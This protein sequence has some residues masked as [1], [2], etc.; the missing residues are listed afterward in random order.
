MIDISSLKSIAVKDE[1]QRTPLLCVTKATIS[2][3]V[4]AI[5]A[6]NRPRW[7]KIVVDPAKNS[8]YLLACN[9]NDTDAFDFV[10]SEKDRYVRLKSR[11]LHRLCDKLSGFSSSECHYRISGNVDILPDEQPVIVFPMKEARKTG[12]RTN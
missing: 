3:G 11:V 8:L 12:I 1:N 9:Q 6:L 2:F 10:K 4:G 5:D 7:A